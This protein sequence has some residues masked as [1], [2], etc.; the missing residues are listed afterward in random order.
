[1]LNFKGPS[2]PEEKLRNIVTQFI[3]ALNEIGN[4]SISHINIT[5][6]GQVA[7]FTSEKKTHH[8]NVRDAGIR[9]NLYYQELV[10]DAP[11]R[12]MTTIIASQCE[13]V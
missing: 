4:Q 1:M 7:T 8:V 6:H 3:K 10:V 2:I 11:I 13:A 12:N 9:K 5:V